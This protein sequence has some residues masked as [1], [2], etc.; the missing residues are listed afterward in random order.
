MNKADIDLIINSKMKKARFINKKGIAVTFGVSLCID[1]DEIIVVISNLISEEKAMD[2][3][4]SS[5]T[6]ISS[7]IFNNALKKFDPEQMIWLQ[8]FP[9]SKGYAA[10]IDFVLLIWDKKIECYKLEERRNLDEEAIAR[11]AE[12]M[13]LP[14]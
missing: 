2:H 7:W 11:L 6:E 5:L 9:S 13:Q 10:T 3:V 14:N 1:K 4:S 8:H 12:L